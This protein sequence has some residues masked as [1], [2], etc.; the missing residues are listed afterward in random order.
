MIGLANVGERDILAIAAALEERSEHPLAEAIVRHGKE[1]NTERLGIQY[2]A[3]V[4]GA[5]VK[6]SVD[7]KAYFF[8]TRKLLRDN[9]ITIGNETLIENLELAGKTVMLLANSGSLIG[10][11]AV[12]DTVKETSKEAV[13][14][15]GKMGIKVYMVTGDNGRSAKAIA[16]QVGIEN[17]LAE[18]LP[19]NKAEEVRKL[20]NQGYRVAMVGDGINDSPAL[21]QAD[22]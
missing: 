14:R 9:G 1:Q 19:E 21:A 18:V 17:V 12:A 16:A 13:E 4:P 15:L 11:I 22:L 20:Q 5:G 3:A 7:S 8:G 2:F 10:L 6:G